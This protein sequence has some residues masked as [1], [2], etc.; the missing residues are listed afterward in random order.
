METIEASEKPLG[1]GKEKK[2]VPRR[3]SLGRFFG[4]PSGRGSLAE[5]TIRPFYIG[6]GTV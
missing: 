2:E 3:F 6:E 5:A 1:F 4:L